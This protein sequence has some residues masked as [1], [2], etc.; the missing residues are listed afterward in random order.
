MKYLLFR[1]GLKFKTFLYDSV[2]CVIYVVAKI[3]S[4]KNSFV[5]FFYVVYTARRQ[6]L[7]RY[8][9]M[10]QKIQLENEIILPFDIP[11]VVYL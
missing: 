8:T 5:F 2:V 7:G 10:E 3:Y 4:K 9:G 6:I 1:K 11:Y